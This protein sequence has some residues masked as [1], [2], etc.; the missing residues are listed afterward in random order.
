[1][2]LFDI[3][4]STPSRD[5]FAQMVRQ[6]AARSGLTQDMVYSE[7]D[8]SL[9]H[10]EGRKQVF[11][12]HNAYHDYCAAPKAERA[13]VLNKYLAVLRQPETPNTYAD[14]RPYLRPIIRSK[15]FPETM[16]LT[17]AANG[18]DKPYEDSS[19]VFSEDAVL[20]IAFDTPETMSSVGIE[21]IREWGMTFDAVFA[22]AIDNLRGLG[23]EQ[24]VEVAPGVYRGTWNDAYDSS[25][26][27]L[28]DMMHRTPAGTDCVI[29]I[30]TRG[31][32]LVASARDV[33]AQRAMVA[34]AQ[35]T[36]AAEQR[37]VSSHMYRIHDGRLEAVV[38]QDADTAQRLAD[39]QRHGSADAYQV[40]KDL[41]ERLHEAQG[42]DLFVASCKLI[43]QQD[44]GRLNTY[45]VWTK[46]VDTL[47]PR[48][49]LIALLVIGED[50]EPKADVF[51]TWD[52]M[53]AECS[54]LLEPVADG[55]PVRY[56]TRGF[57]SEEQFARLP[58]AN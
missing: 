9:L 48:T 53:F 8:F 46:D 27:L 24:F 40:Q 21:Q 47:L 44:T 50:G 13:N 49:D 41:L 28:P 25:R 4:S 6:Q 2:G 10:G 14:A 54:G 55:Y 35:E 29:M 26:C 37:A 1:M 16:R 39:L 7:R 43:Q 42:I 12:L 5:K 3:F 34:V 30:P 11:N 58:A 19:R 56:R 57:P 51:T 45:A 36:L 31:C 23:A 22:D 18:D 15:T 38:P 32:L 33:N 52:A 17:H 20:M